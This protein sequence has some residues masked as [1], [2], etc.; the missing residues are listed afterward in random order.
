[1]AQAWSVNDYVRKPLTIR[2]L[3]AALGQHAPDATKLL[4]VDEDA[5]SL[6]LV[7]RMVLG[8][9]NGYQVSRAYDAVEA[10]EHFKTNQPDAVLLDL[11]TADSR[12]FI[13]QVKTQGPTPVLA[14]SGLDLE[15]NIPSRS[16]CIASASGFTVTEILK[17]LQG[18]LSV[19]PP[20]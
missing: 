10:L 1:M 20:Q 3:R 14:L 2:A 18:I 13:R 12:E 5:S 11:D 17:F 19:V 15:E 7:E 8:L 9:D 4:L 6:R 16:I